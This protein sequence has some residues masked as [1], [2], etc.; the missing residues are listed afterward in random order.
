MPGARRASGRSMAGAQRTGPPRASRCF[1]GPAARA[2]P[3]AGAR[4]RRGEARASDSSGPPPRGLRRHDSVSRGPPEAALLRAPPRRLGTSEP[5]RPAAERRSGSG[6]SSGSP[7]PLGPDQGQAGEDRSAR[8]E[9]RAASRGQPSP[10]AGAA[11]AN[12]AG[13]RFVADGAPRRQRAPRGPR[14]AR[15]AFRPPPHS[16][17][18]GAV[19]EEVSPGRNPARAPG[20]P[21][22]AAVLAPRQPR[23]GGRGRTS[24]G[25][26]GGREPRRFLAARPPLT[27]R[28]KHEY[29]ENEADRLGRRRILL[30]PGGGRSRSPRPPQGQEAGAHPGQRRRQG[31][32]RTRRGRGSR[33]LAPQPGVPAREPRDGGNTPGQERRPHSEDGRG[34]AFTIEDEDDFPNL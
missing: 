23:P 18:A 8:L 11:G 4:V 9:H 13:L 30:G 2:A 14:R 27:R 7:S 20:A 24:L 15:G 1:G 29:F 22:G 25:A 28:A 26:A 10:G 3:G 21:A 6:R 31:P 19:G 5:H 16:S 32:P 33:S 17:A 12:A 34:F